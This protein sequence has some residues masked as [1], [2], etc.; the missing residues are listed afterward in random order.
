[1]FGFGGGLP[2][3]SSGGDASTKDDQDKT[4]DD[5]SKAPASG[6]SDTA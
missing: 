1:M 3:I 4:T 5:K 2:V 6:S